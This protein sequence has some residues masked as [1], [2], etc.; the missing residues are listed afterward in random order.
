MYY[1]VA[2]DTLDEDDLRRVDHELD[3]L[4]RHHRELGVDRDP[5]A[6]HP[7]PG[8]PRR[9]SIQE[10]RF[11]GLDGEWMTFRS[12][13]RPHEGAAG[14]DRWHTEGTNDTVHVGLLRHG[15]KPRPW[16]MLVHPA[17]MGRAQLDAR[18]FRAGKLHRDLGINIAM[19]V[20]P[21]HGPRRPVDQLIRGSFPGLDIAFN[22]HA[23]TQGVADLRRVLGW[24]RRQKATAV[25]VHGFSLGGYFTGLLVGL[26]ADLDAAVIGCPAVDMVTLVSRHLQDRIGHLEGMDAIHEKA[27]EAYLPVSPLHLAP[28]LPSERIVLF[29]AAADRLTDPVDQL[30][31]LWEH[32]DRPTLR[33]FD[34]GHMTYFMKRETHAALREALVERG[35]AA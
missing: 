34:A 11:A 30:S 23:L 32:F 14:A 19:P 16:L 27:T 31:L 35:V 20:L 4:V 8:P 22:I 15:G 21:L 6:H 13:W 29:G 17:E 10:R 24:I 7:D 28:V 5:L 33:W 25:G 3:L 12:G 1:E 2:R 18:M 9:V 26:D